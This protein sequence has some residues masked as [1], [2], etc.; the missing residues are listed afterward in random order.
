MLTTTRDSTNIKAPIEVGEPRFRRCY[1][2]AQLVSRFVLR[3][4][5]CLLLGWDRKGQDVKGAKEAFPNI[6]DLP[7]LLKP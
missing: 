4:V 1:T 2:G 5:R 7:G 3:A 6:D